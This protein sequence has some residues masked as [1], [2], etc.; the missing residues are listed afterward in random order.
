[1][2]GGADEGY[3][4]WMSGWY[5]FVGDRPLFFFGLDKL[6]DSTRL[7]GDTFPY[8]FHVGERGIHNGWAD[9][10]C[11]LTAYRHLG[12]NAAHHDNCNVMGQTLMGRTSTLPG[13]MTYLPILVP[14]YYADGNIYGLYG[15]RYTYPALPP[16]TPDQAL[17]CHYTTKGVGTMFR[18][19]MSGTLPTGATANMDG[20]TKNWMLLH[21]FWLPWN[22]SDPVM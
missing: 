13:T 12:M 7:A 8:V 5:V 2:A 4:F 15:A 9:N 22:G 19:L 14:M 1:M 18:L 21:E 11:I 3:C 20:G 17:E 10:P 6:A 16:G